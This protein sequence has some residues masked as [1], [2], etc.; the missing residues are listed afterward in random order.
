MA[1]TQT[2]QRF[3][4]AGSE[5]SPRSGLRVR[6]QRPAR[7]LF[8]LLLVAVCVVGVLVI[9]TRV[10]DRQEV[11]AVRRTVLAGEQLADA[12]LRVV[13]ISADDSFP[14]VPATA[15]SSIVGQYAKVR[16]IDGSL[17]VA[18]SVQAR[19]LVD[20]S[21]VL[22]SVAVPLSGVPTGLREGSR[23][24]LVVTPDAGE[25]APVL[26]EATVA[27]VPRNLG[28]LVSG[29]DSNGSSSS[30][31]ALTVE[32]DPNAAATVGPAKAVAVAVLAS[33]EPFPTTPPAPGSDV[34]AS[35]TP[36]STPAVGG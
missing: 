28:E 13:S 25:A 27:A 11:L 30:T 12:D 6:P 21:K 19:P 26:V 9:Y 10:G 35:S 18:D 8:G 24:M 20:P 17:L 33:D 3:G 36:V 23:L 31:I 29:G 4:L 5:L 32:V 14:S 34:T 16:M 2:S 22:M 15:R 7:A 1:D